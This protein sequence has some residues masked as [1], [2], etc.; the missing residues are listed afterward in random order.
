[1]KLK[2]AMI[3]SAIYIPSICQAEIQPYYEH[4]KH[5]ATHIFINKHSSTTVKPNE[6]KPTQTEIFIAK[7]NSK[8]ISYNK[9]DAFHVSD[10]GV[11]LN[12]NEFSADFIINEVVDGA[13]SLINGNIGIAGKAAHVIIANPN[14][15]E[16]HSCSFSNTLSETLV[17]GKP[18]IDNEEL[19]GYRLEKSISY[20]D[21][22]A[23]GGK[24]IDHIGKIVFRNE[25]SGSSSHSFNKINIV[26]NNI[27]LEKGFIS[28]KED[29]NIYS[30]KRNVI[31]K[32][33][34]S[35]LE[36]GMR[37]HE[38]RYDLPNR[39]ILGDKNSDLKKQ[40]L[41]S[42]KN[43]IINASDMIIDNYG[44]LESHNSSKKALQL[45]IDK[46]IFNN[47]GYILAKG[48]YLH[49]QNKSLFHNNVNGTIGM[50]YW[51][52]NGKANN[53]YSATPKDPTNDT[54]KPMRNLTLDISKDSQLINNGIL[55]AER[56]YTRDKNMNN[57]KNDRDD[58]K[59][60]TKLL[61]IK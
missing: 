8:G 43:I 10:A 39:I 33:G 7:T 9:Y 21:K 48:G 18:I 61:K 53:R 6:S 56:L 27:I 55:E 13:T 25:N 26:S 51:L 11:I 4:D 2:N 1:M 59:L 32:E 58:I 42:A 54:L 38:S 24:P 28:S 20:L 35:I 47:H 34:A 17:T 14:G 30:G 46:T 5:Y 31:I 41:I 52:D 23:F 37:T 57:I 40:G 3:I 15:I 12:N 44:R 50:P 29:I 16:C 19:I 45:N 22:R 36:N 60:Y 49:L